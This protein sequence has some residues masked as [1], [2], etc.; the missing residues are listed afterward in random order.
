MNHTAIIQHIFTNIFRWKSQ[1]RTVFPIKFK[2]PVSIRSQRNKRQSGFCL[3][4]SFDLAGVYPAVFQYLFN[5]IAKWI[6]SQFCQEFWRDSQFCH[7]TCHI[8]RCSAGYPPE[9][10]CIFQSLTFFLWN[11]I[12]QCFSNGTQLIAAVGCHH[13]TQFID[14]SCSQTAATKTQFLLPAVYPGRKYFRPVINENLQRRCIRINPQSLQ[15]FHFHTSAGSSASAGSHIQCQNPLFIIQVYAL[16]QCHMQIFTGLQK[17]T[18][19]KTQGASF[20]CQPGFSLPDSIQ[21]KSI[22]LSP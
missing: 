11:K 13:R 1:I 20:T 18:Y 15:R 5:V 9:R 2:I 19:L 14:S 6:C 10:L 8:C 16:S 12:N 17:K 3:L 4:I 21:G 7:S 22:L